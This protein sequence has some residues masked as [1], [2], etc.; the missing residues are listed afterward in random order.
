MSRKPL[1]LTVL[2]L[3]KSVIKALADLVFNENE[4]LYRQ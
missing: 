3:G 2:E 4:V 1:F